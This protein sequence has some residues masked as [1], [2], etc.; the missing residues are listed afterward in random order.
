MTSEL[1]LM[2]YFGL[3]AVVHSLS[4]GL[5]FKSW[6]RRLAD[7][8]V[9]RWYRLA[10]NAFALLTIL[11]FLVMVALLPDRTLY[12]IPWSWR[13]LT[14][15]GQALALAAIL[16]SVLQTG[17]LHFV[18][19][20]QVR[21]PDPERAGPLQ[22]HGFYGYM[23]HPLY[24][25]SMV[26]MWLTPVMTMNIAT[27]NVLIS[28]YFVLGSIPEERKLSLEFGEAY[29][30]YRQRVPRLLPRLGRRPSPGKEQAGEAAR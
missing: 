30:A 24:F 3:W 12:V 8:G 10:F 28:L 25:F 20:A 22:M 2:L 29:R 6:V 9:S 15:I 7:P 27:A 14:L 26:L 23:R 18:G 4:A 16:W 5:S 21:A 19:L 1:W 13:W 11:P 17:L